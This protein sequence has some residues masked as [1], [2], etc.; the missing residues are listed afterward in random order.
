MHDGSATRRIAAGQHKHTQH[1][2]SR[3]AVPA[4]LVLL[5][6]VHL[7]HAK[8]RVAIHVRPVARVGG[9]PW[10]PAGCQFPKFQCIGGMQRLAQA[11]HGGQLS[12][13]TRSGEA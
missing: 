9:V 4:A 7:V 5:A 2:N 12:R 8:L 1:L 6:L 10:L 13:C 11:V 3:P